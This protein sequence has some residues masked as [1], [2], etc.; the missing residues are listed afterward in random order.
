MDKFVGVMR[1]GIVEVQLYV[2]TAAIFALVLCTLVWQYVLQKRNSK[3][4]P[5]IWPLVGMLPSLLFHFQHFHDWLTD[6]LIRRG[7]TFRFKAPWISKV[8]TADPANIEYVIKTRFNN[9]GKGDYF[10]SVFRDLLGE[11]VLLEDGERFKQ[12]ITT[13]SVVFGSTG[14]RSHAFQT[15]PTL[16]HG[17]LLPLL[18]HASEKSV[19]IDLQDVLLRFAFDSISIVGIGFDPMSLA[20]DLPDI[21]FIKAFEQAME[22][23]MLRLL[24][25]SFCWKTLRYLGIGMEG[26]LRASR[27]SVYEYMKE[28]STLRKRRNE[29]SA[30]EDR[31][32]DILSALVRLE[33]Q[34]GRAHSE[35]Y[36]RDLSLSIILAGRETTSVALSWFF[37]LLQQHLHVEAKI[38]EEIQC[39][40]NRRPTPS[41]DQS[42][43]RNRD[44][45]PF[46]VEELKQMHYL[47]AALSESLRLYPSTPLDI[48]EAADDDVLPDGTRVD[49]GSNLI[50]SIY[51]VG[52]LESVWGKDC[53]EFKPERWLRNGNFVRES[54]FKYPVFNGGP[55]RCG[56]REFAYLQMKWV[57]ASVI[58]H[59]RVRMV[60]GHPVLPRFSMTMSMKHGLLVAIHPRHKK[61]KINDK[62]STRGF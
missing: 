9:F 20:L 4:G 32:V 30:E 62:N 16:V 28:V 46:S 34:N 33:K 25:P 10:R 54:E 40:L 52:R 53:R 51:S 45:A 42:G 48:T 6:I 59:Y 41:L 7:G 36:L 15:I 44:P 18:H 24:M 1:N 12:L 21:P 22:A 37:W 55:R 5:R 11:S 31:P 17:R 13:I 60:S 2:C 14:F 49:K 29:Y 27:T 26:R 57:A 8:V 47:H 58:F 39:I 50:Y 61:N 3:D 56:G 23:S 35:E 43:D 38:L 19:L